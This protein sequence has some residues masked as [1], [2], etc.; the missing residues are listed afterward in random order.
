MAWHKASEMPEIKNIIFDFGGVLVNLDKRRCVEAFRS[1]GAADIAWYVDECRQEDFFHD[2]EVGDI[3]VKGFCDEVRRR[4]PGCDATDEGICEAWNALLTGIPVRRIEKLLSLRHRYRLML[5]S[6]TNP[7]H[8]QKAVR[9]FFPFGGYGVED[10]FE[11][12]FLSYKMRMLKPDG[13]IFM[14]VLSE[15]GLS[16]GETLFIDDSAAN[17]AAAAE[18]GIMA[19]HVADGDEWLGRFQADALF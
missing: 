1:I 6:N 19:M 16:A 13:R 8:W 18:Q 14:S 5:L 10:Y 3:G 17:C 2:L 12:T 4:C 11:R 9:D 15:A 7:I